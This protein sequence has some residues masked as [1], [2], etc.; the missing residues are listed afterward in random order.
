MMN[1]IYPRCLQLQRDRATGAETVVFSCFNQH[2]EMA[3]VDFPAL[4]RRLPQ[5]AFWKS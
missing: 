2:Q 4:Q 3:R 5:T 1:E